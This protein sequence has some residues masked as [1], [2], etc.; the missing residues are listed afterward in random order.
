MFD[1]TSPY[2]ER[3]HHLYF[4][5]FYTSVKSLLELEKH[6]TYDCETVRNNRAQF[7]TEFLGN[8]EVGESVFLL[9][10]TLIR[11]H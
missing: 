2:F 4:D 10:S 1:L 9:S 5:N 3:H 6:K 8:I 11:V 7:L